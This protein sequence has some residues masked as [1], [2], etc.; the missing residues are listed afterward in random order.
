MH[1]WIPPLLGLLAF[2][3]AAAT[4]TDPGP[5]W[6]EP[7]TMGASEIYVGWLGSPS[8]SREAV[9]HVWSVN[10]EHPPLA[11]V[12]IGMVR[13]A[14]QAVW[15][16]ASDVA[17][18]RLAVAVLFG[19][20][21][22]L[23]ACFAMRF[24]VAGG[25]AG[26][27]FALF[28]PRLFADAHFATLD[29]AMALAWF[30][31]AY[32]FAKGIGSR[33]WAVAAGV[34]FGAA[35][36]AK[37]NAVLIPVP[38]VA[39]GLIVHRQKALVP[40]VLMLA[41]GPA[42][43]LLGWPWLWH[44]TFARLNGYLLGTTVDRFIVPVYYL[45]RVYADRYAPWHYP[46]VLTM[47]TVPAG[48]LAFLV[49]GVRR[50]FLREKAAGNVAAPASEREYLLLAAMNLAAIL[51]VA[52]MPFAPKYDGVRLFLPAFPFAVCIAGAGFQWLWSRLR[53]RPLRVA[54]WA[55]VGMQSLGLFLYHPYE[56]SCY[57]LLC[58]GLPGAKQIGLE[59]TYWCDVYSEPVF[60]FV[61]S[62]P[63]GTRVAFYP[64]GDFHDKF[65]YAAEY[66]SRD[67]TLVD[68]RKDEFDYAVL[69]DR[70]GMLLDNE[71]AMG[72]FSGKD[73]TRVFAIKRMGL[74]LCAIV[75]Q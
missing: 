3:C 33:R 17:G 8:F 34:I 36:L 35:L 37:I 60:E 16:T 23:T 26:G 12:W 50:L 14:V 10:H 61:N 15:P 54:A 38:L 59:T 2:I 22:G 70:Q 68:F 5:V 44:D 58:G 43:F 69:M 27:L 32:A 40:A 45:G 53:T 28:M 39:W 64:V 18:S 24:G 25:I 30:A 66:V 1:R 13:H 20:L 48:T 65:Y 57:N 73:G 19:V 9:D 11:K 71:K 47:F 67:I 56:T 31:T 52:A 7:F 49:L 46:L 62:L 63:A 29:L 41:I 21:V 72:L 51:L 75:K 6:D 74:T 4:L 55:L 42:V